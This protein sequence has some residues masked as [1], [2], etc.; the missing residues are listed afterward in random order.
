MSDKPIPSSTSLLAVR[1]D[2]NDTITGITDESGRNIPLANIIAD[3]GN[4]KGSV[5]PLNPQVFRVNEGFNLILTVPTGAS[6]TVDTVVNGEIVA[7]STIALTSNSTKVVPTKKGVNRYLVTSNAG[8]ISVEVQ[9]VVLGAAL[10]R[11]RFLLSSDG[12][13]SAQI[14]GP[15]ASTAQKGRAD[16]A[17]SLRTQTDGYYANPKFAEGWA[18]LAN[19]TKGTQG[20]RVQNNRMFAGATTGGGSNGNYAISLGAGEVLRWDVPFTLVGSSVGVLAIGFSSDA[21][22]SGVA[23]APANGISSC[24]YGIQF[25]LAGGFGI[26]QINSGNPTG[27]FGGL[28]PPGNYKLT[29][30]VDENWIT[31]CIYNTDTGVEGWYWRKARGSIVIN[32]LYLYNGDSTG[33]AGSSIGPCSARKG[34]LQLAIAGAYGSSRFSQYTTSDATTA[35]GYHIWA[36]DNYDARKSYTLAVMFHGDTS[37]ENFFQGSTLQKGLVDAGFFAAACGIS[38]NKRTWGSQAS[39]DEYVKLVQYMQAKYNIGK[40]VFVAASMGGIESLNVLAQRKIAVAAWVGLAP[41]ANLDRAYKTTWKA[42]IDTSYGI[43]GTGQATYTLK[44]E[45]YDPLLQPDGSAFQSVPMMIVA[46]TDDTL[47]PRQYNTDPLIAK[48]T[49]YAPEIFDI[50][51]ITGGHSFDS[52]PYVSQIVDFL[53]RYS[54]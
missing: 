10:V 44:T 3:I 36:P 52:S 13:R 41:T 9:N 29:L 53:N 30:I 5:T 2:E 39:I 37:D 12:L 49:G 19:W 33:L 4:P 22:V 46:P 20:W 7:G 18:D 34:G 1:R 16:A 17:N 32:N 50:P 15:D 21:P 14:F 47:V 42:P 45:G 27:L 54:R 26:Q 38:A 11:G 51:G 6:G 43:T 31:G 35:V 23:V 40:I 28:P 8:E 25:T 48:C 24:S